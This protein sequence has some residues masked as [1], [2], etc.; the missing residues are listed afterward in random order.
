MLCN[1]QFIVAFMKFLLFAGPQI[2][3]CREIFLK[4]KRKF[5]WAVEESQ[6]NAH[7]QIFHP[8]KIV[9]LCNNIRSVY[10]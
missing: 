3:G 6:H 9:K 1:I 2:V 8:K 7:L 5:H 10:A 4:R